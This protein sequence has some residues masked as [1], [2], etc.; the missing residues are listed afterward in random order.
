MPTDLPIA[1]SLGAAELPRR[2]ATIGAIGRAHLRDV[3]AERS[4]AVL[5]FDSEARVPLAAVVAAEAE[6]CAFLA[7]TL[8]D[9]PGG[10]LALTIEAPAGAEGVMHD[11]VAAFGEPPGRALEG[12]R[13]PNG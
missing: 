11:L 3:H 9:A 1:C 4:R 10:E 12:A 5:R 13:S 7:M 6:C 8:S 2:I